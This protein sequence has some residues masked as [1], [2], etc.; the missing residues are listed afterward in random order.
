VLKGFQ[1]PSFADVTNGGD[2]HQLKL[3][4]SRKALVEGQLDQCAHLPWTGVVPD[5]HNHLW[6]CGVPEVEV[7]DEGGDSW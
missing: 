1:D 5:S 7:L 2:P 4:T 6:C 3:G